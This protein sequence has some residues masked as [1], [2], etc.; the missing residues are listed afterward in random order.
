MGTVFRGVSW[1]EG[2]DVVRSGVQ[3][4]RSSA[5]AS[6]QER[7]ACW[8]A[9]R[10]RERCLPTAS[11]E[12]LM[13]E[14]VT[15]TEGLALTLC[16]W[17]RRRKA[18]SPVPPAMSRMC[19]GDWGGEE[20]GEKPGLRV[21]TKWSLALVV[22][23][24]RGHIGRSEDWG[25]ELPYAMPPE[26]HE[27][28]HAVVRLGYAREDFGDTVLLLGLRD[29]LEAEVGCGRAGGGMLLCRGWW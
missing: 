28:V 26:G 3:E 13:S 20:S 10:E 14:T 19:C 15:C 18:M 27:V 23:G 16:A 21:R 25:D 1:G 2:E 7:E 8:V 11:M 9:G 22:S 29:G 4:E 24:G 6:S 17:W 5:L 12:G